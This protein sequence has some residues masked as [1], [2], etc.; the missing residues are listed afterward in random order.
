[1]APLFINIC[2]HIMSKAMFKF[3]TAK[4]SCWQAVYV[5]KE[6]KQVAHL[7][8]DPF[9][10]YGMMHP[11]VF[12]GVGRKVFHFSVPHLKWKNNPSQAY[13]ALYKLQS[14]VLHSL[15]KHPRK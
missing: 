6:G 14:K 5:Y 12:G 10:E 3:T 8:I 13:L 1:M 4:N 15:D 2:A 9:G 11:K 7:G